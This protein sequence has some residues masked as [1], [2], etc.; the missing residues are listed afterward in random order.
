M[1]EKSAIKAGPPSRSKLVLLQ[2]QFRHVSWLG[3][4]AVVAI[5]LV[6]SGCKKEAAPPP[7]PPVVQVM[8]I[9]TT[10][11]PMATEFIGQLDSPQNVEV[12]ARVEAFVEKI[13]FAEGSEVKEGEL[14]F[15]LDDRPYQQRLNAANGMLAESEAALAKYEADVARLA[16]LAT[17]RAIPKQDLDNALA[18]V[19]VGK[20]SVTSAWARV[21]SAK[22]DLSYCKVFAPMNGLIGAKQVSI[23]ELV[24]KGQP[25][26]MATMSTLD[27]IWFYCNISEVQYYRYQTEVR[28]TGKPAEDLVITLLLANGAAHP[29]KGKI[30]FM[31]RAVDVKTGTL[32]VR[33]A[34][35]NPEKLLRPGMFAR[36]K[37]DVGARADS[38]L[39]P[40][41]AVTELQG[42]NFVWVVGSEDKASQRAVKVGE[43]LGENLLILEGLNAGDRIITEGLQKVREGAPVLPKTAAQMAGAAA[44]AAKH[45][46]ASHT[47][48]GASKHGKE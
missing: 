39:V 31:D 5:A 25:T 28:R 33:A 48:E 40:E 27:P 6:V 21:E 12:R 22:L 29:Q 44:E 14:L 43:T 11:V 46:E 42:K 38:I 2:G 23:G 45:A 32:R 35:P 9:T 15:Q 30:V 36:I 7:P 1:N 18:S 24:G 47:K 10:N 19:D 8:E 41:R 16:P 20:A 13:P 26:L 17:N 34:F 37:V 4:A 3:V